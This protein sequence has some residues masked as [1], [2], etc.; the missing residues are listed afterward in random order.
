MFLLFWKQSTSGDKFSFPQQTT[1]F[2]VARGVFQKSLKL[3]FI[4][5]I[6]ETGPL[7]QYTG[8]YFLISEVS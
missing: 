4:L 8:K 1:S 7:D 2:R 5:E 6:Y 3:F